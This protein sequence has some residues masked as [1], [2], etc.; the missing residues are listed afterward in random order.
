M[1][2]LGNSLTA[3]HDLPAMVQ[4]MAA[5]G[6][7]R[8]ECEAYFPGGHNLEDHWNGKRSRELLIARKWNHV[9][10]QQG[11]SSLPENRANLRTWSV[12][13]AEEARR[14][15]A[16]PALYMVWPYQDQKEGFERVAESYRSAAAAARALLLPAGEAWRAIVRS[17]SQI[18]LYE[19]DKL[20]PT[21][22]GSYLAALVLTQRLTGVKARKIPARL[23]LVS[24]RVV[25]LP[26]DQAK[27][28]R[29]TAERTLQNAK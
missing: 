2:F 28:L 5:S 12:Q 3:G 8:L 29:Q 1:L 4:A 6:G 22:A 26:E 21:V 19:A 16:K 27:R 17:D 15:G 13:W 20:H 23:T 25:E 9:V 14:H 18:A 7:V 24:G 10:L 11:P